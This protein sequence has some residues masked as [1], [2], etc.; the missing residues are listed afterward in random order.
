MLGW[1]CPVESATQHGDRAP[2]RCE[3]ASMR[4]CVH[5]TSQTA[6]NGESRSGQSACQILRDQPPR[7]RGTSR[8][9]NRDGQLIRF[10]QGA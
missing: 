7:C 5:T 6:D 3:G 1:I 8:T 4:D 2:A 10:V 9:D